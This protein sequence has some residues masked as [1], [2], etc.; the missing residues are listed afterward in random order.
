MPAIEAV[1]AASWRARAYLLGEPGTL[2]EGGPADL[3]VYAT[4]PTADPATLL[5]PVRVL[6]RG[7]V[8]H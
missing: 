4:D 6:L 8:V 3:A 7:R 1:A 2:A 5:S